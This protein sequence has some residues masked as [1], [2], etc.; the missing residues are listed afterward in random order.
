MSVSVLAIAFSFPCCFGT[1]G[2]VI[3]L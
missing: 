2:F 1:V 3:C